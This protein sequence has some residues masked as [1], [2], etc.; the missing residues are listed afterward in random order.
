MLKSEYRKVYFPCTCN[1]LT[2]GHIQCLEWLV[3]NADEVVVGLLT[4]KAL[5]GYKREIVPYK[6]RKYLLEN[7]ITS[8]C[9]DVVPQDSLDPTRN[10][11]KYKCTALA[12]GDG[13]EGVEQRAIDT[14]KLQAIHIHLPGENKKRYSSSRILDEYSEHQRRH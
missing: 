9:Y 3:N 8:D 4:A 10:I 13:F 1:I 7:L 2:P 6:D 5:D 11:I 14:L 12:S